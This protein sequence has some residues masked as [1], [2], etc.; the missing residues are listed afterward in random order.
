MG[1]WEDASSPLIS[2]RGE[3][4]SSSVL[5]YR[6]CYAVELQAS[7]QLIKTPDLLGMKEGVSLAEGEEGRGR[8]E[9]QQ[10]TRETPTATQPQPATASPPRTVPEMQHHGGTPRALQQEQGFLQKT[11]P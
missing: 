9:V 4:T 3:R 2:I 10:G 7:P 11:Q 5:C 6:V 1:R 8:R